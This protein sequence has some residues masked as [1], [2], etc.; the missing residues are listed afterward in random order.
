MLIESGYSHGIRTL[1]RNETF[2]SRLL[3]TSSILK[4]IGGSP[5]SHRHGLFFICLEGSVII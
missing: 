2:G 3:K 1:R 4:S 5:E